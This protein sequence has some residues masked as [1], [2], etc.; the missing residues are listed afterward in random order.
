MKQLFIHVW[1]NFS[2]RWYLVIQHIENDSVDLEAYTRTVTVYSFPLLAKGLL[3][4]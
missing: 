2:E 3:S 1:H 4:F